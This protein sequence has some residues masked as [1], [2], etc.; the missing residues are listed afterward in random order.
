MRIVFLGNFRVDFCS[1]VHHA[2]SLE[3]M[4]HEV[5]RLQ[6]TVATKEQLLEEGRGGR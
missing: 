4:G 5:V 3:S 6:E 1:E 2:K